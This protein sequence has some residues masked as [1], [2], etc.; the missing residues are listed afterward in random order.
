MRPASARSSKRVT[1]NLKLVQEYFLR[2][3]LHQGSDHQL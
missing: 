3:A 1:G 2:P